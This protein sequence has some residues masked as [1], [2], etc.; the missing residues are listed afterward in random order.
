MTR[1]FGPKPTV[2]SRFQLRLVI[3]LVVL[4]FFFGIECHFQGIIHKYKDCLIRGKKI[5]MIPED[6]MN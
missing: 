5:L 6:S 3:V 1:R 4:T 2:L